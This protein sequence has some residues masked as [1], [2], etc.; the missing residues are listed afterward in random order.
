MARPL[1][2]EAHAKALAAAH[3]LLLERGIDG[4]TVEAVAKRSGVA[5]TTIYRHWSSAHEL[6]VAAL[7]SL[8]DTFPTPNTGSLRED[9]LAF[10]R[11]GLPLLATPGMRSVVMGLIQV[12]DADPDIRAIHDQL[13]EQ[14]GDPVMIV[15]EL[16]IGR[17]EIPADIDLDLAA[18]FVEGTVFRRAL[19][20]DEQLTDAQLEQVVDWV[21]AGLRA[22]VL[23]RS[24]G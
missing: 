14:R 8:I 4:F 11:H 5:K 19:V 9:L 16:A 23:S 12:A 6:L 15:L 7:H 18:D 10:F 20:R 13:T 2:T 3:D 17:G 21:V 1:S 24:P 22:G